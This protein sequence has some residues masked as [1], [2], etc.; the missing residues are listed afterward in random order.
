MR[1][2]GTRVSPATLGPTGTDE[3][4]S[5][6]EPLRFCRVRYKARAGQGRRRRRQRSALTSG[7]RALLPRPEQGEI[8]MGVRGSE[9]RQDQGPAVPS[10]RLEETGRF[11]N[12]TKD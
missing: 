3:V 1:P 9:G 12:R 6:V 10:D 7:Q 11:E 4:V 5:R 2:A 8:G